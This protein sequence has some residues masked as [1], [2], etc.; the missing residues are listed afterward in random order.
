MPRSNS[1]KHLD[2]SS[3]F[4]ADFPRELV[5]GLTQ[6]EKLMF[7]R[8]S[9]AS[10]EAGAFRNLRSLEVIDFHDNRIA[11]LDGEAFQGLGSLKGAYKQ[12]LSGHLL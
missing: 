12:V 9:L 3:N 6:L 10:L 2:L 7:K 8:N 11:K 1:V 4:V 5:S